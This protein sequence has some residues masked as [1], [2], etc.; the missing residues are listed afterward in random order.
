M[1]GG[2]LDFVK[3]LDKEAALLPAKACRNPVLMD[4]VCFSELTHQRFALSGKIQRVSP[5]VISRRATLG[6]TP[7]L[8]IVEQRDK[9]RAPDSECEANVLLLQAGIQFDN[10]QDAVLYRAN[11]ESGKGLREIAKHGELSSSE[12]ISNE[13]GEMTEINDFVG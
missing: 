8:K 5:L 1:V 4:L 9:I 12:R 7:P 10:R 2:K 3:R 13:V 6:Q 11:V